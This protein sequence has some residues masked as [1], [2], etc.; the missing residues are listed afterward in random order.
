MFP[1]LD[2]LMLT[3]VLGLLPWIRLTPMQEAHL[4]TSSHILLLQQGA[5]RETISHGWLVVRPHF[6]MNPMR[7]IVIQIHHKLQPTPS[8]RQV[9]VLLSAVTHRAR[10]FL[11]THPTLPVRL[12]KR[13]ALRWR[14]HLEPLAS[15]RPRAHPTSTSIQISWNLT[16]VEHQCQ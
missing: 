10:M 2:L 5:I 3:N 16:G 1:R 14:P 8:F 11:P 15:K 6:T 4:V 9:P 7:S 13:L 12:I